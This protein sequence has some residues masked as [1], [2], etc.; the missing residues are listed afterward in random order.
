MEALLLTVN[1]VSIREV[2]PIYTKSRSRTDEAVSG[3]PK[4][5]RAM[6]LKRVKRTAARDRITFLMR[7]RK[8]IDVRAA[9]VLV[10]ALIL[11]PK[12]SFAQTDEITALP[13]DD[14]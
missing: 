1:R 10:A 11:V 13:R 12:P 7:I 5:E 9:G 6:N 8:R 2:L 4:D 14:G 3:C